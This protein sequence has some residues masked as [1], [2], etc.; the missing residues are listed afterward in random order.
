[1]AERGRSAPDRR[2]SALAM[3]L[4]EGAV[5]ET[6]SALLFHAGRRAAA[7]PGTRAALSAILR[8]EA[9]HARLC[10]A[11]LAALWPECNAA[12]RE[13]L[14]LQLQRSFG[15]FEQQSVRASLDRL[16]RGERFDPSL[17]ALGVLPPEVRVDTFYRGLERLV[18]PRLASL[19]LD[20]RAA[21]QRRYAPI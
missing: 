20:A 9:R 21:W 10:W 4:F 11:G 3:L 15:P 14:Q 1:V 12:D 18:L 5:G 16:E 2:A 17:A 13:W 7:E 8:D 6:I 19:G